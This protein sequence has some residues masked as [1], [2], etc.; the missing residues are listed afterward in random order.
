MTSE[1]LCSVLRVVRYLVG[2]IEVNAREQQHLRQALPA[3][4]CRDVQSTLLSLR[5]TW[6][7]CDVIAPSPLCR[8]LWEPSP[9]VNYALLLH[10]TWP[11]GGPVQPAAFMFI[12]VFSS[13]GG[14][15]S[16]CPWCPG[17]SRHRW[18]AV[19]PRCGCGTQPSGALCCVAVFKHRERCRRRFH[20]MCEWS[21]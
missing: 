7:K 2:Q 13:C 6:R 18:A 11:R 3:V 12:R 10:W 21:G 16:H 14:R 20:Q 5:T 17:R 15:Y 1:E 19:K 9:T 8:F 4:L